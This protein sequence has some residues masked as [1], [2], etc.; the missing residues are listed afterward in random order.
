MTSATS[1]EYAIPANWQDFE[2]LSRALL[3]KVYE[4]PFQRWGRSGQR[5]DG[6]DIWATLPDGRII[7]AQCKGRSQNF[8]KP[9]SVADLNAAVRATAS[10]PHPIDELIVLTTAADD[11][12]LQSHATSLT[13]DRARHNQSR[14]NVWDGAPSANTSGCMRAYRRRFMVIGLHG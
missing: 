9:L 5:Q 7:A 11:C 1:V 10:F 4:R 8:G 14:V 12:A 13:L 3:S 6:V 2:R